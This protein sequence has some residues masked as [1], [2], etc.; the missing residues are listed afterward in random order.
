MSNA[1]LF[2][3]LR[4]DHPPSVFV[5]GDIDTLKS[6]EVERLLNKRTMRKGRGLATEYLVRWKGYGP[7]FDRWYNI[8]DLENSADLVKEYEKEVAQTKS[9]AQPEITSTSTSEISI[10]RRDSTPP[11]KDSI[12][13]APISRTSIPGTRQKDLAVVIPTLKKSGNPPK[14]TVPISKLPGT[15]PTNVSEIADTAT[16]S[17][18]GIEEIVLR[19]SN[20]IAEKPEDLPGTK[21]PEFA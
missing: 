4:P 20:R 8:K 6:Y 21:V 2:E 18:S 17:T 14:T 15:T 19:R 3:R 5:E 9:P 11:R 7:A 13:V 10:S 1:D 12:P 16:S